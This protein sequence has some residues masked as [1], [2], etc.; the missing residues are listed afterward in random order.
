MVFCSKL[1]LNDFLNSGIDRTLFETLG[2]HY[3]LPR[4]EI[5]WY[6][7]CFLNCGIVGVG[8]T[9]NILTADLY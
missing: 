5:R 8:H 3:F 1:A 6:T 9:L 2:H 7:I 4:D